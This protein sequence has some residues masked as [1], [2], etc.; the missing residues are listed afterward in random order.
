MPENERPP[1]AAPLSRER[2]CELL[3]EG[4]LDVEGRMPWSSNVT[5]LVTV[6]L[7]QDA[8]RAIYKPGR[9]EQPLWDFPDGVYRYEVAAYAMSVAFGLDII[10]ETVLRIDA[11]YG[12]GS[13]Q[14]FIEA[15]FE[16]HYFTLLEDPRYEEQLRVIA[17]FD[18]LANNADRKGGHL[19][20][21]DGGRIFAID[22]GLCFHPDP[23]LRTVMWDF[24][25]DE[26]PEV[27]LAGAQA[28]VSS[29]PAS[30][31]EL[32]S[33]RELDALRERAAELLVTRYFPEPDFDGRPYPWPRI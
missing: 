10:P 18:V 22:N 3:L 32:L 8:R 9:G 5:L 26:V 33:N 12:E 23:K 17:G 28:L 13:V 21:D 2:W 4:E 15:N 7:E 24:A 11:P 16:E 31:V 14:R 25:G 29:P 20:V 19:L 1:A 27:I 30:L 6:T